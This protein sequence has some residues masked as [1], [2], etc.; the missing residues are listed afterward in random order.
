FA[1]LSRFNNYIDKVAVYN[2]EVQL[3][4][5]VL[6]YRITFLF[7]HKLSQEAI[8]IRDNEKNDLLLKQTDFKNRLI[9]RRTSWRCI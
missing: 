1:L 3:L 9:K 4:G 5:P 7:S 6:P 8:K 2:E